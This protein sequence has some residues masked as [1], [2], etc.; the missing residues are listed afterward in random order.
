MVASV[1]PAF[2]QGKKVF[3]TGHTGFKGSWLSLWLQSMGAIVRG[4]ALLPP[5]QPALFEQA[6]VA[7]GMESI[8][9]DVRDMQAITSAMVSFNPDV[10]IH[11]AAQPLVRL[12]YREPVAT[13]ATNVMGTV[14][15]LEAARQCVNLKAIVNVTT[16]KCYENREWVWGYRENEPMGGH[17]PYSNSKGCSEL[18]TAA[19]RSSFFSA[20]DN[21]ALASARA[22]NVIGGGDWA[23]DRL[24]PDILRAFEKRQPV[25]IR[26]PLATRPW[27]HVLEPLS[28][29]L[30][31]AERLYTK[32]QA[33]ADGWNFGPRDEDVQPVTWILNHMTERWGTG[34][35]WQLDTNLQPH[36]AQLLK[37]D[38]SKAATKLEWQPRWSLAHALDCIVDWHQAWL[39]GEDMR[40]KTL[41]QIHYYGLR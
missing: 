23:E 41:Q 14:H 1:S 12:S 28:G 18:V 34:A 35:C 38:I 15:V 13:Y 30:I 22:G 37:L 31:L 40:Q 20:P 4:F 19:Y 6:R 32:G 21:A 27:Q 25:T 39:R 10:L 3:L 7:E 17:D 9:G 11:M 8:V 24:I 5:T 26:N 2:W 33:Y 36:E 16:D 29:Y